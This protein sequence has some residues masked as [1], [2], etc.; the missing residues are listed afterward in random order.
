MNCWVRSSHDP[1]GSTRILAH[2]AERVGD[3]VL[4]G[5]T[6]RPAA[7]VMRYRTRVE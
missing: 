6:G 4:G 7:G 2:L 1:V 3:A 5:L